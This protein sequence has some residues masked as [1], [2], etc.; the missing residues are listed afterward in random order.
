MKAQFPPQ[1][2]KQDMEKGVIDMLS[3]VPPDKDEMKGV[4]YVPWY[5]VLLKMA[6][7]GL[8]KEVGLVLC[9]FQEVMAT[10]VQEGWHR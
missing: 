10:A 5:A 4:L 9:V 1:R 8:R 3:V 6:W 7:A 2:V